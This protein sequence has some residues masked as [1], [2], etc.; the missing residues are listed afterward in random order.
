[1]LFSMVLTAG[2]S[3][4]TVFTL[5]VVYF[6]FVFHQIIFAATMKRMI[7]KMNLHGLSHVCLY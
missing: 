2:T 3:L 5:L 7:E 6:C 4:F 1:M